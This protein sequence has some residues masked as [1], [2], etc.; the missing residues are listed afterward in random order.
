M[1]FYI[2][3]ICAYSPMF[4]DWPEAVKFLQKGDTYNP[5]EQRKIP[6]AEIL[7]PTER[8]R[9]SRTVNL[10]L[11]VAEQAQQSSCVSMDDL[12]KVFSCSN[13]DSDIFNYLCSEV[14]LE[15]I[16]LS[17]TKFHQSL[18]NSVAGYWDIYSGSSQCSTSISAG[19]Y[20]FIAG[21]IESALL[22]MNKQRPVLYVSYD[23]APP[24]RLNSWINISKSM[25]VAFVIT[26]KPLTNAIAECKLSIGPGV[27]NS[28][29]MSDSDLELFRK[30]NPAA[31]SLPVLDALA[32]RKKGSIYFDFHQGQQVMLNIDM[33]IPETT[34]LKKQEKL[35]SSPP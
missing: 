27:C 14:S 4:S 12:S 7:S 19:E 6:K 9:A 24:P 26:A 35:T 16:L 33:A 1:K 34:K 22:T 20:S 21:L 5:S 18:H 10:A 3:S 25:A 31:A 28:T 8:R 32:N 23:L 2:Q 13:G 30:T 15:S 11:N 29:C 17:P